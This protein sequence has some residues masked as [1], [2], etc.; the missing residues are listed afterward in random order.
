M[1][2][3]ADRERSDKWP[4]RADDAADQQAASFFYFHCSLDARAEGWLS[5]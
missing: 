1:H 2:Q 3:L 4:G 5:K